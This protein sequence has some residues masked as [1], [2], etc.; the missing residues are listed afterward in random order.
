MTAPHRSQS[1][2]GAAVIELALVLPMFCGLVMGLVT[3]AIAVFANLQV[4]TAAAEGARAMYV[5][6]T[7]AEAT[8]AVA[9]AEDGTVS[10]SSGGSPLGDD[11]SCEDPAN[12]GATVTVTLTRDPID[13]QLLAVSFP[14]DVEGRT[15]T[16]CA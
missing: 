12:S 7:V 3:T 5:G 2:D 8:I 9:N 15:V 10:F 6:A 14:V 1:D 16:Q 11:W 4:N 13:I